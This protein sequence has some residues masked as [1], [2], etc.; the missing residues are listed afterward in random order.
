MLLDLRAVASPE[1]ILPERHVGQGER[2]WKSEGNLP[3]IT[4]QVD[5][6]RDVLHQISTRIVLKD[7]QDV[8]N[9]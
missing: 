8:S 9:F 1:A 6:G 5:P 2:K 3:N 7:H 4:E